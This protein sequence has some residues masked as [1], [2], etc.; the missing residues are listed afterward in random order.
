MYQIG[1]AT[2]VSVKMLPYPSNVYGINVRYNEATERS[3]TMV[4]MVMLLTV[5]A[6]LSVATSSRPHWSMSD[7]P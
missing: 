5:H 1:S 4:G 6:P 2:L 7:S 3:P